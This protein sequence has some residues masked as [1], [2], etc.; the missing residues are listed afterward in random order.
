[1]KN[2]TY[3]FQNPFREYHHSESRWSAMAQ[4]ALVWLSDK[5]ISEIPIYIVDNDRLKVTHDKFIIKEFTCGNTIVEGKMTGTPFQIN[6]WPNEFLNLSPDIVHW[7][8]SG[9]KAILIEVKTIGAT[10]ERNTDVYSHLNSFLCSRGW[11]SALYYLLSHGHENN[12]D[13]VILKNANARIILWEDIF[14]AIKDQPIAQL[15]D[16]DLANYCERPE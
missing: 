11:K 9:K 12:K 1:M 5:K 16:A 10:V 7:E 15:F 4:I 6:D 3:L 8:S 14:I 2:A 13:W